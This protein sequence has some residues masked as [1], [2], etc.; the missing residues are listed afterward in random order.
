MTTL[1]QAL[2]GSR[3]LSA[4]DFFA[5]SA[6]L[7]DEERAET[8]FRYGRDFDDKNGPD[9]ADVVGSRYLSGSDYSGGSLVR[10]N[11]RAV[12]ETLGDESPLVV[13]AHGGHNTL[14]LYFRLDVDDENAGEAAEILSGLEN[15]PV[16]SDDVLSAQEHDEA[17][18]AWASYG[19]H[20]FRRELEARFG[21]ES[22]FLSTDEQAERFG[23]LFR[24]AEGDGNPLVEH[25][26]SGPYFHLEEA[27]GR[28]PAAFLFYVANVDEGETWRYG[29]EKALAEPD[30]ARRILRMVRMGETL[31]ALER[32][33]AVRLANAA[34]PDEGDKAERM[35]QGHGTARRWILGATVDEGDTLAELDGP[36]LE[37]KGD[38]GFRVTFRHGKFKGQGPNG[39]PIYEIETLALDFDPFDTGASVAD[40]VGPILALFSKRD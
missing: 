37:R 9:G 14:A 11:I 12:L 32:A 24:A 8:D 27:A 26:E 2:S 15:Y 35:A 1:R 40:A 31:R 23:I 38:R 25:E 36:A 19:A 21:L 4:L 29:A 20:D 3:A 5:F 18:S 34:E 33:L 39:F 6:R 16:V 28:I 13:K 10:A 7:S 17:E 22:G 30:E